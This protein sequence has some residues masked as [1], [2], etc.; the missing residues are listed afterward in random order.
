V[1]VF[2]SAGFPELAFD[3][4]KDV[5][6]VNGVQGESLDPI[7]EGSQ[8]EGDPAWSF[9]ASRVAFTSDG[10]VFVRN[11]SRED[12]SPIAITAESETFTD[13]AWAPTA[14]TNTIAMVKRGGAG[15]SLQDTETSLCFGRLTAR[16]MDTNCKPVS[17][18]VIGR[19]LNWSPDGRTLL[20]FA[21]TRD[22]AE[23]GMLGY[24]SKVPF[25][26]NPDDWKP[27]GFVTDTSKPG[28]GVIDAAFSPTDDKT[29][30][31]AV[32]GKDGRSELVFAKPD[33]LLL[34]DAKPQ[35]VPACKVIW[36]PDGLQLVVVQADDC[37]AARTGELVRISA[38][39]PQ[40]D[41]QSLEL[42]GDN[43]VFQPLTIE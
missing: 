11:V 20:A 29:V 22:G 13:L 23:L 9:D 31:V 35:D 19:K 39:N 30:A 43:P 24:R 33:D 42:D 8:D 1:T 18:N 26:A 25:S 6:L 17:D 7:A 14:D 40:Q 36:R 28:Q 16:R 27:Q 32:L 10:Q 3:D 21:T 2:V 38:E 34:T 5:L 37:F 15:T 4:D 12:A 41:Q